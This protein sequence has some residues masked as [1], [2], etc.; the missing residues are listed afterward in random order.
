MKN[1]EIV[2]LYQALSGINLKG[3]KFAYAVA[4]NINLIQPELKAFDAA[5]KPREDY[6]EYN[7]QRAELAKQHAEKDE[8]G[9]PIII[10]GR[11]YKVADEE[12]FEKEWEVLKQKH[13]E[14][15]AYRE[16][17]DKEFHELMEKD[18]TVTLH[19]LS[20][21]DVPEDITSQQLT[22]IFAIVDDSE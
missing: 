11:N 22:S 14:A 9:K 15:I 12:A 20:L 19:K 4:K 3:P 7:K 1:K 13:A 5:Q 6:I 21:K 10:N 8:K 17:Q 16:Q 2:D 18:S